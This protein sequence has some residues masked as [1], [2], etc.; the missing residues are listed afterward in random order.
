[1]FIVFFQIYQFGFDCLYQNYKQLSFMTFSA[2]CKKKTLLIN[3]N[4]YCLNQINKNENSSYDI[5]QKNNC[6][7]K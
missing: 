5:E 1:M 2:Y 3:Y 7:N 6:A 4:F